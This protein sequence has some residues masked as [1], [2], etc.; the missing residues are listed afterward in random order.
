MK[1]YHL[2]AEAPT[3]WKGS[4]QWLNVE[5]GVL[6]VHED[7]QLC[8][9]EASHI[10]HLLGGNEVGTKVATALAA[11]GVISTDTVPQAML[12]VGKQWSAAV[13]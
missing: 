4:C 11:Y 6:L 7:G 13:P 1:C 5:G 10:G 12:K 9:S 2:L 8:Q 3:S